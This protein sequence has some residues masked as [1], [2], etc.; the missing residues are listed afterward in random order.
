MLH[1]HAHRHTW[2][3]VASVR[4]RRPR[5]PA[6]SLGHGGGDVYGEPGPPAFLG[7]T[8]SAFGAWPPS[9]A[10]RSG[11]PSERTLDVRQLRHVAVAVARSG[12]RPGPPAVGPRTGSVAARRSR[13]RRRRRVAPARGGKRLRGS[14]VG[15][16]RE[17][18][19]AGGRGAAVDGGGAG[20][21]E[22]EDGGGGKRQRRHARPLG[23]RGA[24]VEHAVDEAV[25]AV[26]AVGAAASRRTRTA[27]TTIA[28]AAPPRHGDGAV[29]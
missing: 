6:P 23:G 29:P 9:S 8:R 28:A 20:G 7:V 27:T 13:C 16:P 21:A 25:E 18:G 10:S 1:G 17:A 2:V 22:A 4:V 11:R 3:D 14:G 12:R 15:V 24:D 19:G 5:R 26:G